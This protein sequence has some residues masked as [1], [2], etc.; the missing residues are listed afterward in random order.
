MS[1]QHA[2]FQERVR[3]SRPAVEA[4]ALHLQCDGYETDIAELS[5]APTAR[6]AAKYADHGDLF[7]T[8][9]NKQLTW[10]YEVKG[11]STVFTCAADWPHREVF[12][13]RRERVDKVERDGESP[14]FYYSVNPAFTHCAIID[15][16]ATRAHW[17]VSKG[18]LNKNTGNHE[19]FYACPTG[20]VIFQPLRKVPA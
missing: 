13:D 10:L 17:Y 16:P 19:D 15:V 7:V 8:D 11:L 18:R 6:Q 3:N 12:V 5:I 9:Y 4:V 20:L 1:D 2:R 14:R